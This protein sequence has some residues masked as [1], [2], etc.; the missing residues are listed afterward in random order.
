MSLTLITPPAEEPITLAL[1]RAQC[2]IDGTD[3]DA[4]LEV[5]I[6][7]ARQQCEQEL[8]RK[9]ITQTVEQRLD[10][11]PC[12]GIRL[13]GVPA[14]SIASVK[15]DDADGV[16]QT[17]AGSAYLL[18]AA[19]YPGGWLMPAAGTSWPATADTI[20]CVRIRYVCGFGAAADVPGPI[21]AW[22][23]LAIAAHR[24]YSSPIDEQGRASA[25]PNRFQERLLDPWRVY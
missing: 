1:A 9:L 7:S 11:F 25:L 8:G 12:G 24:Q 19:A 20:N 5:Y 3:H 13:D 15:Y 10:A 6:T 23:L 16:E 22:L 21:R 18:D 4:L 14:Q 17:L 2:S